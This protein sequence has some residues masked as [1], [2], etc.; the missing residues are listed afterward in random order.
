MV[1]E[2]AGVRYRARDCRKLY[3]HGLKLIDPSGDTPSGTFA[4]VL[5]NF[6]VFGFPIA[7]FV[8]GAV[9]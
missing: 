8:L 7:L 9:L 3:N 6:S 1:A 4:E 5:V 2:Q